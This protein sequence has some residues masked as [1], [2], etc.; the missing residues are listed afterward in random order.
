MPRNSHCASIDESPKPW[1]AKVTVEK[2]D[3]SVLTRKEFIK[4]HGKEKY[5]ELAK[6]NG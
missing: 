1:S 4:K 3:F 2:F 5:E 6:Q